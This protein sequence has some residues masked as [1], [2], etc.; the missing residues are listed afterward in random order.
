M[1]ESTTDLVSIKLKF[2]KYLTGTGDGLYL[3][4]DEILTQ[5]LLPTQTQDPPKIGV[6]HLAWRAHGILQ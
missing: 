4:S 6:C 2:P 5:L 3:K 1:Y